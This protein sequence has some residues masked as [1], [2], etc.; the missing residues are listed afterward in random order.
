MDRAWPLQAFARHALEVIRSSDRID[1][2][3][4]FPIDLAVMA[5]EI[6]GRAVPLKYSRTGDRNIALYFLDAPFHFLAVD[7][8]PRPV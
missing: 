2:S 7:G 3:L 1:N 4:F 5:I 6:G 8:A